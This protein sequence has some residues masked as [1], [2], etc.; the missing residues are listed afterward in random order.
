MEVMNE[1]WIEE[2]E[3]DDR[4]MFMCTMPNI[5]LILKND[6]SLQN[7]YFNEMKN[8]IDV[9]GNVAWNRREGSWKNTDL[10]C[11]QMYLEKNYG[12]YAP[13]K[14]RDAMFAYLS[15]ERRIH[16]VRKY[17]ESL[18]WD[19]E[20][21]LESLLVT[22]LGA[23][24][25]EYVRSVTVKTF[26]AAVARVFE[27]GMKFD[28]VLV[29]CG[30]QGIGKSTL[31]SKLGKNWYSDAMTVA[32]MKDKTAAEK[33]QGIWLMELSELA[34]LRKVD[35]E[36]IKSFLSRTD[37][38]Y[39]I[40]Y[41]TYVESHPRKCIIVATTNS[42]DG[43][44]RDITGNRR[45]WP[46]QVNEDSYRKAW[47]MSD[48][49]IDQIWAEAVVRYKK[50]EK[51]YLDKE[52]EIIADREQRLAMESDPRQGLIGK[53]LDN[54]TKDKICLMELW[55]KCLGQER[56]MMKRNDAF[57]LEGILKKIGGWKVY[58]G[59]STGKTRTDAYGVQK[60]FV[61]IYVDE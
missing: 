59:N 31:F 56:R 49:E 57:E 11:L 9:D 48:F 7:I 36:T 14:C 12:L 6:I 52:M 19:G 46:V 51:L 32:D 21:R 55:C 38:Q 61:R 18:E 44:L 54:I 47:N 2:L 25:T 33:L 27:S 13:A 53:Y 5:A 58:D 29:L 42:T 30:A 43:F 15:A 8:C 45:F 3:R 1:K 24:N 17:L 26:T 37:D 34:G 22:Y 23:Q 39:R 4:G 40:P 28:S 16:P 50:G 41:G 10:T 35:V 60:T 20:E